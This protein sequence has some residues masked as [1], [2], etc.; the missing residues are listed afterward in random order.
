MSVVLVYLLLLGCQSFLDI[1]CSTNYLHR[2]FLLTCYLFMVLASCLTVTFAIVADLDDV[3]V[4]L[5]DARRDG[6]DALYIYIYIYIYI[7]TYIHIH[8]H[9]CMHILHYV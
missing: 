2:C 9:T 4:R 6:A 1:A 7:H 3:G 8:T 5:G